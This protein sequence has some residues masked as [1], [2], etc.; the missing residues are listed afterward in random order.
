[1]TR[2]RVDRRWLSVVLV[3]AGLLWS[4]QGPLQAETICP[5]R[6]GEVSA[7]YARLN[8]LR[9]HPG[10]YAGQP[11]A[12]LHWNDQLAQIAQ[13]R[14]EDMASHDY[15]SHRSLDGLGPNQRLVR[16]GYRLPVTYPLDAGANQVESI[17]SGVSSGS[18]AIDQLVRD[19]GLPVPYHRQQLLSQLPAY[20]RA[21]EV[22]I[23]MACGA[24]STYG[25]YFV[26]LIAPSPLPL[27]RTG[28][29]S[30]AHQPAPPREV[31]GQRVAAESEHPTLKLLPG[32]VHPGE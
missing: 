31:V 24:R 17:S 21:T 4:G 20:H 1:M 29:L 15:F 19:E 30:Q 3:L 11:V 12:A 8:Y 10:A 28:P 2:M 18:E 16:A 22:G 7:A 6:A 14:A 5:D 23:G 27:A 26:V 25:T 32:T 13:S 9:A